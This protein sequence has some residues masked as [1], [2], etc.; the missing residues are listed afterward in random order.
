MRKL[1]LTTFLLGLVPV[2]MLAQGGEKLRERIRAQRVAI[3]TDV[4]KLT[5][6]EA[7]GFWP[8]YNQFSDAKEGINKEQKAI[9][10]DNLTDA[11]AEA[12]VKK[13]IEL[14]QRELDLEKDLIQKLR[15]VISMQKIVKL[16]EAERQFRQTVLEK[17]KEKAKERRQGGSGRPAGGKDR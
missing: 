17:V 8:I 4:L 1:F 15:K 3:Y 14:R 5:P 10:R 13:H 9:R 7:E 16:P 11:E 2:F 6:E 12:Q